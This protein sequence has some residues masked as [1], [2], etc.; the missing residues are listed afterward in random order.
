MPLLGKQALFNSTDTRKLNLGSKW[1]TAFFA[2]WTLLE[3]HGGAA[4]SGA[5]RRD[6][7]QLRAMLSPKKGIAARAP[8]AKLNTREEF[9]HG[10]TPSFCNY[11]SSLM[12]IS[13]GPHTSHIRLGSDAH[14]C[15]V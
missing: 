7:S 4:S 8:L 14:I 5:G 6:V 2:E 9:R 15:W 1:A 10:N 12:Q 3:H 13:L 11:T